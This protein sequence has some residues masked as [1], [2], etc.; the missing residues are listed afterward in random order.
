MNL[1]QFVDKFLEWMNFI[2]NF[3]LRGTGPGFGL[4]AEF[5]QSMVE[6]AWFL[7]IEIIALSI[8]LLINLIEYHFHVSFDIIDHL[9]DFS[10]SLRDF[11]ILDFAYLNN[12]DTSLFDGLDMTVPN[13]FDVGDQF[14][15]VMGEGLFLGVEGLA[16]L[17]QLRGFLSILWFEL[18]E[19]IR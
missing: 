16:D 19:R 8:V 7:F 18:F 5:L 15:I 3:L 2:E 11:S 9:M 1:M 12:I 14:R 4:W 17:G 13:L 6:N 10:N